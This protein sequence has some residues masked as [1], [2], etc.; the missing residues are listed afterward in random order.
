[1]ESFLYNGGSVDKRGFAIIG[2]DRPKD[3]LNIGA[4]LRAA[5]CYSAQMVV[6]SNSNYKSSP[7]DT[8]KA[9]WMMFL[10]PF[11]MTAFQWLLTC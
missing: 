6:T 11:H 10:M 2:L 5:R 8:T 3:N 4:V 9:V 1:M 7:T